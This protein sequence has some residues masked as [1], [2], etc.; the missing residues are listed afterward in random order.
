MS[1]SLNIEDKAG[2][3]QMA[4][5]PSFKSKKMFAQKSLRFSRAKTKRD[6]FADIPQH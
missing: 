5:F 4:K 6:I 3:R 1:D 2:G